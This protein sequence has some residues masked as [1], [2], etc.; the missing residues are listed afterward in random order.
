MDH[1]DIDRQEVKMSV[2]LYKLKDG[3]Y[4]LDLKRLEGDIFPF[5]EVIILKCSLSLWLTLAPTTKVAQEIL[6]EFSLSSNVGL[7][8]K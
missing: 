6:T 5:L 8:S 7:E 1:L 2:Q 4:L 3:N